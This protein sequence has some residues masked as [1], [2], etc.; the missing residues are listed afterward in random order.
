MSHRKLAVVTVSYH[1]DEFWV[2]FV[3]WLLLYQL[4]WH[5]SDTTMNNQTP[6][7]IW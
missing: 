6:Q 2:Y 4:N 5:S 1:Y 7:T 3:C